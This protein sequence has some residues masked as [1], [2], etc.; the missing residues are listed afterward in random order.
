MPDVQLA[1]EDV[2]ELPESATSHDG[3]TFSPNAD[4][5]RVS[6]DVS[7]TLVF[8]RDASP[9]TNLGCRLALTRYAEEMSA[10]HTRNLRDRFARFMRD[11]KATTVTSAAL[12]NCNCPGRLICHF[13]PVG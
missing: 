7:F 1:L 8:L 5:W 9:K 11:T 3:Y 6:K 2:L 4:R 10:A 13:G 12:I